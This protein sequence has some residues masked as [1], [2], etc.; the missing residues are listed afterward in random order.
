MVKETDPPQRVKCP[1]CESTRTRVRNTDKFD[2]GRMIYLVCLNCKGV[3][4]Y[5]EETRLESKPK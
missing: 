5:F 2:T 1:H 3:M 4:R